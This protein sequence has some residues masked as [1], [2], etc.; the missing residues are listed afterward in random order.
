MNYQ[1]RISL[2]LAILLLLSFR[3]VLSQNTPFILRDASLP[4]L[5]FSAAAWGDFDRDGDLDLVMN[6]TLAMVPVTRILQNDSGRFTALTANLFGLHQGSVNWADYDLDG[7]L[8]VVVTGMDP[9]GIPYTHLLKNDGGTFTETGIAFPGV[10]DGTA[11]WGDYNNDGFPDLFITG[12]L[13]AAIYRNAGDSGFININAQLP[14]VQSPMAAWCDYN[15]DGWS[16]LM[17]CGDTGGGFISSLFRN[18]QGTFREVTI[19]PEPFM[20]LYSGSLRW[21]DL[22]LDGD[23]DLV[24][25]GMDLYIDAFLLVYRNDG[26]DQFTRFDFQEGNFLGGALDAGDYNAD[27]L[28]DLVVMGR[29]PGCGGTASTLLFE[30]QGYM[31]FFPVSTLIPGF[32]QGAVLW[33]DYN[34][35]GFSDLL[36]TGMDGFDNERTSLYLNTLGDTLFR[37]NTLPS[38]PENPGSVLS[39]SETRLIWGR[40]SDLETPSSSLTYN[41]MIGTS[42]ELADIL[43]PLAD[44]VTGMRLIAADGNASAD[45]TWPVRGLAP[46]NYYYRVQAIDNG[47][48]GGTFSEAVMFTYTPVGVEAQVTEDIRISPNPSGD[49]ITVRLPVELREGVATISDMS[50]RQIYQQPWYGLIDIRDVPPGLYLLTITSGQRVWTGKWARQ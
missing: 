14:A 24:I 33:G 12:N 43:S 37:T 48:L 11:T 40:A 17:I 13:M 49:Y 30:N 35:D 31:N 29:T 36:F 15:N 19:S 4:D 3:T 42:P 2:F 25:S 47:Y 26:N 44:P 27:G 8:D 46:G 16:D 23:Q 41:L 9:G 6:G 28:P 10:S 50:G 39:G 1:V 32:K 34:N 45:T 18:D 38:V 21:A 20:G 22:D 5:G 7:D